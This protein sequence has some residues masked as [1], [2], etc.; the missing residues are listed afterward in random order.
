MQNWKLPN[1]SNIRTDRFYHIDKSKTLLKVLN[2]YGIKGHVIKSTSGPLITQYEFIPVAGT[3]A[4]SVI[5]LSNDIARGL[6]VQSVNISNIEKSIALGIEVPNEKRSTVFFEN[7]FQ[8]KNDYSLPI[9][10]GQNVTGESVTVD[11]SD[12]PHLLI[13][14]TTGSGKSVAINAM[15]LSLLHTQTPEQCRMLLIDPKMVELS[16]YN[17]IPHLIGDV[18]TDM[19][20]AVERLKWLVEFMETRYTVFLKHSVKNIKGYNEKFPEDTLPY[21]VTVIDELADLMAVAGKETEGYIQRIAQ[22]AR[23]AGIHMII[24]TQRP[25][26]DVITGVIKANLPSRI[27]YSVSSQY[28]SMTIIGQKGAENL[29]GNGDGLYMAQGYKITRIHAPFVSE[30]K[31]Q[32]TIDFWK[33]QV[34]VDDVKEVVQEDVKNTLQ[35][36]VKNIIIKSR[37]ASISYICREYNLG[38]FTVRNIFTN[39]EKEGVVSKQDN[40]GRRIITKA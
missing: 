18:V 8:Q 28:D 12:M 40:L 10:L 29:L 24:A 6:G 5:A 14:G 33:N 25:S 17:G 39:L 3:M 31:I 2:D 27:S 20:H 1:T 34:I 23:A 15:L 4:K 9:S 13:A 21:I 19:Q 16:G 36:Y 26:V 32:E 7:S 37:R 11:L 22:K 30:N 35:D 38:Y